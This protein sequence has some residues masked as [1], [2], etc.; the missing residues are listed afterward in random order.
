MLLLEEVEWI[1]AKS[2][3][4]GYL[5]S[6]PRLVS[7]AGLYRPSLGWAGLRAEL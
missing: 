6:S 1:V 5:L 7:R 4:T 3:R 2:V